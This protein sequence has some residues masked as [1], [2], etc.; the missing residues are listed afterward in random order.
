MTTKSHHCKIK[1]IITYSRCQIKQCTKI[2]P[3]NSSF[4]HFHCFGTLPICNW[5][6]G[7]E[8]SF[9]SRYEHQIPLFSS[10]SLVKNEGACAWYRKNT[11][12]V[13]VYWVRYILPTYL[14]TIQNL[15]FICIYLNNFKC[16]NENIFIQ[17]SNR[18]LRC[19]M[20]HDI[21]MKI[22]FI[23]LPRYWSH[24]TTTTVQNYSH[25]IWEYSHSADWP[26]CP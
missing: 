25:L 3:R 6:N 17:S 20:S 23:H 14:I 19:H 11:K 15:L 26:R 1:P 8:A 13:Y 21:I 2:A 24:S 9:T 12:L 4:L 18:T 5:I 7:S 10:S 16:L 22:F